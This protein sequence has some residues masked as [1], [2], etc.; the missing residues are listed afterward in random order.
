MSNYVEF[1]NKIAFHPG[2]YIKELIDD[3]GMTQEELAERLDTTLED[4]NFLICGE[5]PLSKEM[6]IKLA[7]KQGCNVQYWLNLQNEYD[8]KIEQFNLKKN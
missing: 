5:Q 4:L 7:R 1:K 2:Y 6:A 3:S 8:S